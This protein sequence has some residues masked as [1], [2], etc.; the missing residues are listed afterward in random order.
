M[1]ISLQYV[2]GVPTPISAAKT[3]NTPTLLV[4]MEELPPACSNSNRA[5]S[6]VTIFLIPFE[7][8]LAASLRVEVLDAV[9]E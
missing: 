8:I 7:L 4:L 6:A 3:R 5:R 2:G 1:R 9:P